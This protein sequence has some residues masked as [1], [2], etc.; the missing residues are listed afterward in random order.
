MFELAAMDPAPVLLLGRPCYLGVTDPLCAPEWWTFF[1]YSETVVAS[2]N[3]V[4]ER[5]RQHFESL[6]LIGYSGGG[7]LAMLLASRRTDVSSL[8]TLAGNL[9]TDAWTQ[10]H[11]YTRLTGSLNPALQAPLP[12]SVKQYHLLGER[13]ENVTRA[14][15]EPVITAQGGAELRVL[16]GY[17]HSCC[18]HELW[19]QFLVE[20]ATVAATRPEVG[21][22]GPPAGGGQP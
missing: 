21:R 9:D 11:H 5:Q 3:S 7:T 2:M 14:M 13:D 1:R 17:D 22:R 10:Y 4:L 19:P 6:A 18:W 12:V 20:L 16:P 15:I 8:V